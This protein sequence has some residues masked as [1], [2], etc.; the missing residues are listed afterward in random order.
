MSVAINKN[1]SPTVLPTAAIATKTANS[2]KRKYLIRVFL[3]AA[4][5]L[6]YTEF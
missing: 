6:F 3:L 5:F 1:N 4:N 2:T